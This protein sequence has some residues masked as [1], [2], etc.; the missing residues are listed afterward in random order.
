MSEENKEMIIE[1]KRQLLINMMELMAKIMNS[2]Q[3]VPN[4]A[5][6]RRARRISNRRVG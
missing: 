3:V 2:P 5:D 1:E 6:R 4:R